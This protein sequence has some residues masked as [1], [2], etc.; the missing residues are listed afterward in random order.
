[1]EEEEEEQAEV[2]EAREILQNF[3]P[4]LG[5]RLPTIPVDKL[6]DLVAQGNISDVFEPKRRIVDEEQV[7]ASLLK[8][9]I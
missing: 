7:P 1:M 4:K 5:K 3:K 2:A 9:F 8:A 6:T